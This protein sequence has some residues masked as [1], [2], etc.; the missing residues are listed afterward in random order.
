MQVALR[1]SECKTE[2]RNE[3]QHYRFRPIPPLPLAHHPSQSISC[4]TFDPTFSLL[5]LATARVVPK[6]CYHKFVCAKLGNYEGS[7]M[8][9]LKLTTSLEINIMWITLSPGL[10]QNLQSEVL[11]QS[12]MINTTQLMLQATWASL[13][14]NIQKSNQNEI[15]SHSQ[16][17]W[18]WYLINPLRSIVKQ[19]HTTNC[20]NIYIQS[21]CCVTYALC[22]FFFLFRK[23]RVC[24][25]I[26]LLI[27]TKMP[28]VMDRARS[29][30][31]NHRPTR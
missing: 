18:M 9:F 15:S 26:N 23:I 25:F 4:G 5:E 3:Q 1:F 13:E 6:L 14:G 28:S 30:I 22:W 2:I 20:R 8:K 7:G 12:S 17:F 19:I 29:C 24:K 10:V 16:F 27:L 11:V 31:K 21:K